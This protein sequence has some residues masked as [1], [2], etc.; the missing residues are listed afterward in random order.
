[1]NTQ[2]GF[3]D[4]FDGLIKQVGDRIQKGS[5][6]LAAYAAGRSEYL[7]TLVGQ[8]G[9]EEAVQAEADAVWLEAGITAVEEG[10]ALDAILVAKIH[11]GLAMAARIAFVA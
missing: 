11:G 10:D 8:P 4:L 1:M 6:E 7:T 9:F 5:A 2:E 3:A